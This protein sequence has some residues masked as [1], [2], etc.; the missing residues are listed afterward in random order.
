[1]RGLELSADIARYLKELGTKWMSVLR[2]AQ[3]PYFDPFDKLRDRVS[4]A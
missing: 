4:E 3:Q 1:M 2:Q